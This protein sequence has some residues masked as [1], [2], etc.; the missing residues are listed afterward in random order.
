MSVQMVFKGST[1][2]VA[3][4]TTHAQLHSQFVSKDSSLTGLQLEV[5]LTEVCLFFSSFFL[6]SQFI[7]F[8]FLFLFLFDK[9]RKNM[10]KGKCMARAIFARFI[11][12]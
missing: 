10:R 5:R 3:A 2:P 8:L 1:I 6:S 11:F 7:L 12:L 4:S 9:A